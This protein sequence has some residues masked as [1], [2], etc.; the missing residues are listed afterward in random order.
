M[1]EKRKFEFLDITTADIAFAAYGHDLK[2]LFVNSATALF[3]VMTDT[4][5]I[6]PDIKKKVDV[7]GHDMKSLMFNWLSELIFLS[8]SEHMIFSKFNL[9]LDEKELKIRA[10]CYGE[11][12]D[13]D[14]HEMRTEVK[15]ATYHKMEIKKNG[16]WKAQVIVD[17]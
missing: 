7:K 11:S 14:R 5:K 8:S 1:T 6:N 15:A 16:E 9:D 2:E 10:K 4:S 17:V 12:I 3:E 13:T